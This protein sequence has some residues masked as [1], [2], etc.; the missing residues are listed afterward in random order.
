MSGFEH[1]SLQDGIPLSGHPVRI[2]G[3][4]TDKDYPSRV[5]VSPSLVAAMTDKNKV[6]TCLVFRDH[7][8]VCELEAEAGNASEHGI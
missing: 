3:I 6:I 8:A 4:S 2:T 7:C 5:Y 1:F